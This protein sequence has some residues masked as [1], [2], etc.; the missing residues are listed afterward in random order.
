[1]LPEMD[2][3]T[4]LENLKK[5][6]FAP[7]VVILSNLSQEEDIA[8]VKALGA[9]EYFVKSDTPIRDIITYVKGLLNESPQ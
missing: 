2:G 7:P 8:K 5:V 3:F 4:V 6:K 1:M 9:K